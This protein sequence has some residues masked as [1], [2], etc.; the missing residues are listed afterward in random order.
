[1][2]GVDELKKEFAK[3]NLYDRND[4]ELWRGP[5][6]GNDWPKVLYFCRAEMLQPGSYPHYERHFYPTADSGDLA[7]EEVAKGYFEE[8]VRGER[9]R[10][11][12]WII[13][14]S[15]EVYCPISLTHF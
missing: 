10:G 4:L 7:D 14:S 5:S 6:T 3:N 2:D 12:K 15:V 1:M 13:F 9:E 11:R 8:L